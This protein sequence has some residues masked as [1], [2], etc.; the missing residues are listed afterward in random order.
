[1]NW[2]RNLFTRGRNRQLDDDAGPEYFPA[3]P[4]RARQVGVTVLPGFSSAST[5]DRLAGGSLLARSG[6][7]FRSTFNPAQPVADVRHF[8]G[9]AQLLQRLIRAIEDQ[10]MH[11]ILYGDRGIGKTS[12]LRVITELAEAA[13]YVVHYESCG[14]Q[15]DFS[16]TFRAIAREIPLLFH[17]QVD[18][19]QEEVERGGSLADRLPSGDFT[20][21]QLSEVFAKISGRR[22]LVIL[23]EFDRAI[24]PRFRTSIAE[25]IKNLSDRSIHVQ[26][27]IAGVAGNL[28]ELI[29]HIP[30]IRRNIIGIG[31]PNMTEDEVRDMVAIAEQAGGPHF[32]PEALM[33]LVLNSAGLPYLA[34]LMGQHATLAAAEDQATTVTRDHIEV[35]RLR[36]AEDILS[37][38]SPTTQHAIANCRA[39]KQAELIDRLAAHAVR[40]DGQI[41]DPS[42]LTEISSQAE[43]LAG[44]VE[45]IPDEPSGAWRFRED[46]ASSCIWL[47]SLS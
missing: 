21:S 22:I 23:D 33:A 25:L 45:P 2:I 15:S 6:R 7:K 30:S 36:T 35:A 4:V 16:Q 41:A 29:A 3:P 32:E 1:M 37:R 12:I 5:L 42:L 8:A 11:V 47:T 46:G 31:V 43:A 20:V 38:L 34:S 24:S 27:V 13:N 19:G 26:I 18:P 44:L 9:R 10:H 28:T 40:H 14:E 39:G 17:G